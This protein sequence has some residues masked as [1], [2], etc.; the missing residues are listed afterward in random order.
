MDESHLNK[1]D[2]WNTVYQSRSSDSLSW[3]QSYPT[4]TMDFIAKYGSGKNAH[5][6]DVGGGTSYLAEAL[7][8]KGFDHLTVL[9]ISSAAL[10]QLKVRLSSQ[11][12]HV[13]FVRSDILDFHPQEQYDIWHDRAAFH[14]LT[15]PQDIHNYI[16]IAADAIKPGGLLILATFS[17]KGPDRCSNLPVQKYSED[18]LEDVLKPYFRKIDCV[19]T[20]HVTPR[21]ILQNFTYCAFARLSTQSGSNIL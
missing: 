8:D 5:I 16:H 21:E 13:A 4:T 3:Y 18:Q 10:D 7:L 6:L 12:G 20:D 17:D 19:Y 9:D 2:H 14:F 1:E 15:D 11:H